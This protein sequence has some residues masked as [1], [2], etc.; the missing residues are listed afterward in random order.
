MMA[1]TA[2]LYVVVEGLTGQVVE[3]LVYGNSTG[4]RRF[5]S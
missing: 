5:P 1:W 2:G 3:P 4:I